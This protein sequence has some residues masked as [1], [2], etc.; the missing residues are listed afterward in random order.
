MTC[1]FILRLIASE[2]K[3]RTGCMEIIQKGAE[4]VRVA[5]DPFNTSVLKRSYFLCEACDKYMRE[6]I[7]SHTKGFIKGDIGKARREI[8]KDY[9]EMEE[10]TNE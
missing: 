3:K 2:D 9:L 8:A 5:P 4:C 6:N 10:K 7:K 1:G